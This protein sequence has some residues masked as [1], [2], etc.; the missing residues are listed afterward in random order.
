MKKIYFKLT[1]I[2]IGLVIGLALSI[3]ISEITLRLCPKLGYNY[4][5][6]QIS[7]DDLLVKEWN[8]NQQ[9]LLRPSN[10]LGYEHV[11]NCKGYTNSYGLRSKEYNLKK[12]AGIYRI[13]IL[14]DSIAEQR[15][16]A[17]FLEEELNKKLGFLHR[18]EIWN[19]GVDSYDV[20][21][22]ALFLKYRGLA[23]NPDMVV[24]F[25]FMNDFD[26]SINTYYKTK[27][28][29]VAYNFFLEEV[30][31]K[32]FHISPFLMQH[33]SVYRYAILKLSAYLSQKGKNNNT[34]REDN[35]KYYLG[36]IKEMCEKRKAPLCI[37]VFPYL[38]N[39]D[40]Y[41]VYQKEEYLTIAKVLREMKLDYIDL[42]SLYDKLIKENFYMRNS[43]EDEIH[44]NK[45]TY[46]MIA[47][48]IYNYMLDK[49]FHNKL[50]ESKYLL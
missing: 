22:Y 47:N 19:A 25:L 38:K 30:D 5:S 16:S 32:G 29:V 21:R 2:F 48:I 3:L 42:I 45:E 7:G 39:F 24:V 36:E 14:G 17:D 41:K 23:Y 1:A 49:Y 11:P 26:L 50:T 13:L 10:L 6:F 37:I 18:F 34:N 27:K 44:P 15:W 28:G 31:K 8:T 20:R 33:S 40:E 4:N 35:G 12:D 46:I 43:K 9:D